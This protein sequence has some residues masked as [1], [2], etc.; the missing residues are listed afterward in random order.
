[1]SCRAGSRFPVLK[2]FRWLAYSGAVYG[3]FELLDTLLQAVPMAVAVVRDDGICIRANH[4]L[5]RLSGYDMVELLGRPIHTLLED[6]GPRRQPSRNR[7]PVPPASRVEEA[8]ARKPAHHA[9]RPVPQ[10]RCHP[11]A[12]Q[13]PRRPYLCCC[14]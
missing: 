12:F 11:R 4:T 6:E 8:P 5:C 3:R 13:R 9:V 2:T 7:M 14:C 1:M 10:R